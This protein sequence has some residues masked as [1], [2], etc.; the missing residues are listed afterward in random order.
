VAARTDDLSFI[1][2]PNSGTGGK[3]V[4]DILSREMDRAG[5]RFEMFHTEYGGHGEVLAREAAVGG[6]GTVVAVGGDGTLNEVARGVVG[7]GAAL[8]LLPCGSGNA[9]ARYAGIPLKLD[10]A[11]RV[12]LDSKPR[13]LDVGSA[14]DEIFLSSA[15][16]GIDAEVC[17]RFNARDGGRRGTLPYVVISI[18]AFRSYRPERV[19]VEMDAGRSVVCNPYIVTVANISQYGNGAVI[20]PEARPDDGILDV[21]VIEDVTLWRGLWNT[22]RLFNGTIDQMP[23]VRMFR[24]KRVK[25]RRER[26][27]WLQVDGEARAGEE[28]VEVEVVPGAISMVM[29]ERSG[30][31]K[32]D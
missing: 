17:R 18:D 3:P 22:R 25:I 7:T 20:A 24:S 27:G 2:N 21:C 31:K 6:C 29:P 10:Q 28:V 4:K 1:I 19:I 9:F 11:C 30:D 8:G 15:G 16:F 12:L 26:P 14:G 32:A 5:R 13:P 23:G